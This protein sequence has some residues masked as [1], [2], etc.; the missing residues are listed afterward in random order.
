MMIL[1]LSCYDL[2]DSS[3]IISRTLGKSLSKKT[4]KKKQKGKASREPDFKS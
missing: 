3:D 1:D 2:L 4:K